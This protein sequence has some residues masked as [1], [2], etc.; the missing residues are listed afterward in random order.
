MAKDAEVRASIR[1]LLICIRSSRH[2][3]LVIDP[4]TSFP[5]TIDPADNK[6][7]TDNIHNHLIGT[8]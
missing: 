3:C 6:A 4:L 2:M 1:H 8:R 5:G 7:A